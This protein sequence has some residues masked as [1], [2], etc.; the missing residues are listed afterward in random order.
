MQHIHIYIYI[1]IYI[2]IKL[3]ASCPSIYFWIFLKF[4]PNLKSN[5][6]EALHNLVSG[7]F[8]SL[9]SITQELFRTAHVWSILFYRDPVFTTQ[10]CNSGRN[11]RVLEMQSYCDSVPLWRT[12]PL[13]RTPHTGL[14]SGWETSSR[15]CSET[16]LALS[17]THTNCGRL[18]EQH[19]HSSAGGFSRNPMR[20]EQI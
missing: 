12:V 5:F 11:S 3:Q 18:E 16:Q 1:Y 8:K 10:L 14:G 2:Y 4:W 13:H 19:R 20:W 17:R 15:S 9:L 7:R 6:N